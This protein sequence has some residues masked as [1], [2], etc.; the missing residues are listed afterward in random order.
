MLLKKEFHLTVKMRKG[1]KDNILSRRMAYIIAVYLSA[2][3]HLQYV[4][5]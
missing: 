5:R 1:T 3:S 2:G 4:L